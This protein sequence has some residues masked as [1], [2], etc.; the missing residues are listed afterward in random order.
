MKISSRKKAAVR[1][2]QSAV[3][4]QWFA[5]FMKFSTTIFA[6]F[7]FAAMAFGQGMTRGIMSPPATV[8]PPGLQHVGITQNLNQ[9]IPPDLAFTDDQGRAVR[10]GDYFGKK[11]LI[12]NLVYFTCPMLCGEELNGLESSLRVINFNVGNEFDVITVS[13]DPKDTPDAAAK[14]KAEILKRYKRSG[15]DQGWHFLVGN[16]DSIDKIA[17][18]AG[19]EYEYDK[20]T[21]QFAHTTAIMVLTP[22]GKIAQYYYGIDYPPKDLR[23]ALVDASNEKIGTV[24]DELLL[25]CYHYDPE[26]GKYSATIMR[27]LRLA[28]IATLLCMGTVFIVL[29]RRGSGRGP[30]GALR[31]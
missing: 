6:L 25:Y 13:F 27:I 21:N 3:G 31:A 1:I 24:V 23:L 2:K 28:G 7:V 10:L 29:I 26:K 22:Q 11:P 18:A 14:K 8:R 20:Q 16:Q 17:K 12:L 30:Q 9:Q 4:S 19:F 15:A 5:I